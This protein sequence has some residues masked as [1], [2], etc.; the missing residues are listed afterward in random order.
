VY[1]GD[2]SRDGSSVSPPQERGS[3]DSSSASMDGCGAPRPLEIGILD[4]SR[5]LG[6]GSGTPPDGFIAGTYRSGKKMD[7]FT[8]PPRRYGTIADLSRWAPYRSGRGL[9]SIRA[10]LYEGP[11]AMNRGTAPPYRYRAAL[12]RYGKRLNRGGAAAPASREGLDGVRVPGL[13][14]GG[15]RW[16][17]E[18]GPGLKQRDPLHAE[19][20]IREW[21]NEGTLAAAAWY[22][23]LRTPKFGLYQILEK[24]AEREG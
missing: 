14:R 3:L 24:V 2:A 9:S 21:L 4:S 6:Y 7:P 23:F 13:G 20:W 12:Y 10:S 22:G 19:Y 16:A 17:I 18:N 15:R 8:V 11:E 5:D 1:K